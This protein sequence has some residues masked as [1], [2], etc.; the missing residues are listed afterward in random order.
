MNL[1]YATTAISVGKQKLK[2][3]SPLQEGPVCHNCHEELIILLITMLRKGVFRTFGT[4]PPIVLRYE[5]VANKRTN[6]A[7]GYY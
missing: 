1:L 2:K 3:K 6:I 4:R 5:L 7:R